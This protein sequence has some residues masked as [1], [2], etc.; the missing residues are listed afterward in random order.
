MWYITCPNKGYNWEPVPNIW[1][2]I[3]YDILASIF[4]QAMFLWHT[5]NACVFTWYNLKLKHHLIKN[6]IHLTSAHV[7]CNVFSPGI[8][9]YVIIRA[10][11][12]ANMCTLVSSDGIIMDKSEPI[13]GIM[14]VGVSDRH[15]TFVGHKYVT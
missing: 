14:H 6:N 1:K 5:V 12:G 7:W 3:I 8:K 10:C 2:L 9:Y 4:I 11:N 15:Q 13:P